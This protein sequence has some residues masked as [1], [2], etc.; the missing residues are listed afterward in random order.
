MVLKKPKANSTC[1]NIKNFKHRSQ[2]EMFYPKRDYLLRFMQ[3]PNEKLLSCVIILLWEVICVHF[4][5][6]DWP[7]DFV[8]VVYDL[9]ELIIEASL[10]SMDYSTFDTH[11]Q[12]TSLI[13]NECLFHLCGCTCSNVMCVCLTICGSNQ[14][15]FFLFFLFAFGS[16]L[17]HPC[18]SSCFCVK[19]MFS[20]CFRDP[21]HM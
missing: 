2:K 13:F 11:T 8:P 12:H 6:W 1:W 4:Y 9:I 5:N 17:Y 21:F 19:N 14:K 7:L 15:E 16:D 3:K 18:F 10:W 20:G